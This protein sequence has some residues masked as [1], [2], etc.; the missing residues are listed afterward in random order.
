ML[1]NMRVGKRLA[2]ISGLVMALMLVVAAMGYW[3]LDK[4][5]NM[6]NR[7][8]T[9][10]S[11]LVEYSERAMSYTLGMRRYEKDTFINLGSPEK[12]AEYLTKWND[13]HTKLENQLTELDKLATEQDDRESLRQMRADLVIYTTGFNKVISLVRE[14]KIKTTQEAN[15]AIAEYKDDIRRLEQVAADFAAKNSEQMNKEAAI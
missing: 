12:E 6:A 3:G 10:D 9:V 2:L 13:Q 5:T 7:I 4:A 1:K 15:Q 14:G 11:R 8:L